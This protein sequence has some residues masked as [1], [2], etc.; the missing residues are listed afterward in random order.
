MLGL[1]DFHFIN[2]NRQHLSSNLIYSIGYTSPIYIDT[3]S[4]TNLNFQ[5]LSLILVHKTKGFT[6]QHVGYSLQYIQ[7][8]GGHPKYIIY[9]FVS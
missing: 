8:R 5:T 4:E 7:I 3:E 6:I 9:K 2:E 1:T